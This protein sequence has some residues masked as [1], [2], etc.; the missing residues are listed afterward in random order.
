MVCIDYDEKML[1]L[2]IGIYIGIKIHK[3]YD[4]K[5]IIE[6]LQKYFEPY[7]KVNIKEKMN[8]N[9]IPNISI[10]SIEETTEGKKIIDV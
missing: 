2:L 6:D 9:A 7:E 1:G 10:Q 3:K 8:E 5:R 4:V